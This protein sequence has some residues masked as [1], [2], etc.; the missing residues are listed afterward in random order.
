MKYW[1]FENRIF[2]LIL[3]IR[4]TPCLQ[5]L[6]CSWDY[7]IKN[8]YTARSRSF[9]IIPV[10]RKQSLPATFH[11]VLYLIKYLRKTSAYLNIANSMM[12]LSAERLC[13]F[14]IDDALMTESLRLGWNKIS[15]CV[16]IRWRMLGCINMS[17]SVFK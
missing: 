1:I 2:L 4:C 9:V 16:L 13:L 6:P 5:L 12:Y 3:S 14:G 17:S 7:Y 8:S 10:I 11:Y 15:S